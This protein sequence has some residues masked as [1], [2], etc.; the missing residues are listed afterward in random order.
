MQA[1]H[2][3]PST[4]SIRFRTMHLR[5][6]KT[7]VGSDEKRR[8]S[9]AAAI[10]DDLLIS[11]V[12]LHLPA[13]SLARCRCVCRSWRGGI[14]GAA[15]VRRHLELSRARPP[16]SVLAIPRE[17]D[18]DD[19]QAT[20]TEISF[21]RVLLPPPGR[22]TAAE[23]D[24]ILE[25]AWPEGIPRIV[26]PTHC[27]GLVA[28]ATTTDRVFVC[29]PAT[30]EFVAL[31]LG[32]HSAQ[33]DYCEILAP[34][35]A[36]GFDQWRNSY[37]VARYFYREYG[38]MSY[39]EV[40]GEWSQD[41]DIGHEV[42]TLGG[43]GGGGGSW[44]LTQDPPHA[45]GVQRPMCTRRAFYWHSDVP[46]PR[47]MRF[48]LQ[49]R[50]FQ[51]VPRPPTAC[52]VIDDMACLDDGRKLYYVHAAAEASFQVWTADDGPDLQWSLRCRIHLPD[53]V[54]NLIYN[55]M[56]VVAE[57]DG[58]L[59]A[60]VGDKLCRYN[61]QRGSMEEVVAMHDDLQYGRPDGSKYK[62]R[63]SDPMLHCVVPYLES[64]VSLTA[65]N[66]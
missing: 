44:E 19:G 66:Y 27:D 10:P 2:L 23:A 22:A 30:R 34:P 25:K 51:V 12:L 60:A 54:P 58:T 43:G 32:T 18:P 8:R 38:D 56:P 1:P 14:G 63:P 35:V 29:N 53:P 11:E 52:N 16:S 21:H 61:A 46:R 37:V 41:Y 31:P 20:S 6:S 4:H 62:C 42:F 50:A 28:L 3:H 40:T 17:V 24:L 48:S 55:F 7:M 49:D 5:S 59:V 39:D 64:L 13:K 26:S 33:L 9:L 65:R 45:V 36:L 57:G 47:L 15:F